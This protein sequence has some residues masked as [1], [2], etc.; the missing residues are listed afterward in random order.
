MQLN[1]KEY[2]EFKALCDKNGIKYE[3]EAEYRE[4]A[5]NLIEYVR[6]TLES[7]R[8]HRS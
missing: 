3:T 2:A 7:A 1:E 5:Y 4:A 8:E 6:L